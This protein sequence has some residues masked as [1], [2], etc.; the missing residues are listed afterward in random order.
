MTEDTERECEPMQESAT[1]SDEHVSDEQTRIAIGYLCAVTAAT[2]AFLVHA[3]WRD[4]A[5]Q[6][7]GTDPMTDSVWRALPWLGFFGPMFWVYALFTAAW[8]FAATLTMARRWNIR[9]PFYYL[10]CGAVSGII[11]TLVVLL[12]AWKH[13]SEHDE[14]FL[15]DWLRL[16][17]SFL[18]YGVCGSLAFWFIAG[19]RLPLPHARPPRS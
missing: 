18:L 4:L 16:G 1:V 14:S 7:V 19:R 9:S 11:L 6:A 8:P 17:P 3:G 2:L 5:L 10:A 13:P 12:P 15:Q